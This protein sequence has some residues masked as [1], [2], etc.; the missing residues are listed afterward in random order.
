VFHACFGSA[1]HILSLTQSYMKIYIVSKK[2]Q[3]YES[4]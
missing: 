2:G 3:L 1:N 4:F